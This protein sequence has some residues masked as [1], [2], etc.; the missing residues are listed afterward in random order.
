MSKW[1]YPSIE[2]DEYFFDEGCFIL[3]VLNDDEDEDCS[4]VR[5]RIEPGVTTLWHRLEGTTERYVITA[6]SGVAEVGNETIEVSVGDIVLIPPMVPQRITNT[7]QDDL[8]FLA[9][10]TPR[11][12]KEHYIQDEPGA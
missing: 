12:R 9:V 11:F 8:V 1:L 3:E 6:G 2:E 4:V 5:A 10:C 7:G